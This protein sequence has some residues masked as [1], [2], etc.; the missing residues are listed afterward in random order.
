M[1]NHQVIS[2]YMDADVKVGQA[3]DGFIRIH[4]LGLYSSVQVLIDQKIA[5]EVAEA[6]GYVPAPVLVK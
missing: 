4:K 1:S 3:Y 5:K 2:L 6:I